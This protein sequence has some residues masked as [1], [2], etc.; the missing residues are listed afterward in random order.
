MSEIVKSEQSQQVS[1][2]NNVMN[3][4][5]RI[6]TNPDA[7]IEKLERLLDMQERVMNKQAEQDFFSAMASCQE[8]MPAVIK[9]K[10][11]NQTNSSYASF[12]NLN[13][14]IKPTYTDHGFSL[15]FGTDNS[16]IDGHM[17]ITCDVFHRGGHT[18]HYFVDMP[19]DNAGIKGSINKTGVH[20]IGSTMSYGKRYLATLIFNITIADQDNDAQIDLNQWVDA[21][22]ACK[23]QADLQ[24]LYSQARSAGILQQ[25]STTFKAKKESFK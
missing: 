17:R 5:E 16:P 14:T 25:L 15:S 18:K 6:A 8:S 10:Q 22:E 24:N 23:T 1:A 20:A 9:D 7:D 12:E 11:N 2:V 19:L 4:V 3:A 13:K 21:I